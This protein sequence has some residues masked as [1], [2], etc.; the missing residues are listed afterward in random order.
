MHRWPGDTAGRWVL[1]P[2]LQ[3]SV[4][5][6]RMFP[7]SAASPNKDACGLIRDVSPPPVSLGR[8]NSFEGRSVSEGSA[9]G[10]S[11]LQTHGQALTPFLENQMTHRRIKVD[12]HP[13]S[14]LTARLS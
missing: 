6:F 8:R 10:L 13:H 7:V 5:H 1:L 9:E 12:V 2:L 4:I 14:L 3:G 11:G